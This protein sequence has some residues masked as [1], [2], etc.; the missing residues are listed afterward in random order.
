METPKGNTPVSRNTV[1]VQTEN[2]AHEAWGKLTDTNPKA[3]SL[4]HRLVALVDSQNAG[5][6]VISNETLAQMT[7]WCVRTVQR[8]TAALIKGHWVQRVQLSK[9]VQ[10]YAVNASVGWAGF[11]A[12]KHQMAAFHAT[13]IVPQEAIPEPVRL[14]RLPVLYPPGEVALPIETGGEPGSQMQ[15]SGMESSIEVKR[16]AGDWQDQALPL[17]QEV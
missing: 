10:G 9:T 17:P 3:A 2:Q 6:I 15:L 4:L 1:F 8:A 7:G 16:T 14:R 13:V 12:N 11:A 5:V